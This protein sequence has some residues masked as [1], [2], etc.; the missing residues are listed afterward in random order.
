M[1]PSA[2]Q[3]GHEKV[4]GRNG[5]GRIWIQCGILDMSPSA[6]SRVTEDIHRPIQVVSCL[7]FY[8]HALGLN[9]SDSLLHALTGSKVHLH[10]CQHST[11]G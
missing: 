1:S 10:T 2:T 3:H 5:S 4:A 8:K 11:G 9:F 7:K 6:L